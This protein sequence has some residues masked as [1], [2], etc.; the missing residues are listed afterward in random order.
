M[1]LL[2]YEG[3]LTKEE[4]I[5]EACPVC[6]GNSN[7]K[8]CLQSKVLKLK[9]WPPSLFEESFPRHCA[10]FIP[11]KEYTDPFKSVLNLAAKLPKA[12]LQADMGPKTYIA[13]GFS[14]ELGWGDSVTKLY[15]D[16]SHAGIAAIKKLKQKHLKQDKREWHCDNR[17]AGTSVNMLDNSSSSINPL[18]EQNSVQ[19]VE[20]GSGL[21]DAKVVD[22][23]NKRL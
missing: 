17:Y 10:E 11:F 21:C 9:D 2:S 3:I 15:C 13:Y 18:D 7:C 6:C 22:P 5:A 19:V 1:F 8:A 4:E 23:V 14:Q 16:M 20:N 12:V